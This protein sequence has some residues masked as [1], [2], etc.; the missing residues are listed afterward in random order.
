MADSLCVVDDVNSMTN[1]RETTESHT[2][3]MCLTWS[4]TWSLVKREALSLWQKSGMF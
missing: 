2:S 4:E 1:A 3:Q